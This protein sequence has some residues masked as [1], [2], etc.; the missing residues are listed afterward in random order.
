MGVLAMPLMTM[1]SAL[2]YA[3]PGMWGAMSAAAIV[4]RC[5]RAAASA[6]DATQP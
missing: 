3:Q 5:G 2:A 4:R 1:H 6:D